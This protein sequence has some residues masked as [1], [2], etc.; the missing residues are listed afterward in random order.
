MKTYIFHALIVL[1]I[2]LLHHQIGASAQNFDIGLNYGMLGDNLPKPTEVVKLYQ[3][4]GIGKMRIFA[5]DP[6]TLEA[7]R[8]SNIELSMGIANE[9]LPT[10]A[11]SEAN[12]ER[13]Y[14]G[15]M[16]PYINDVIFSYITVGNEIVPGE[17]AQYIVPVMRNLQTI[18]DENNL[19]GIRVSTVVATS[20]LGT[21]YPPSQGNFTTDARATMID[22]L[23]FLNDTSSPLLINVY[24]YFAVAA[25]PINVRLDYALFTATDVVV[26]DGNL[27]YNNMFDAI[28]DSFFWA[29]EKENFSD[30]QLVVSESGWPSYGNGN[31]TTKPLAYTY[32]YNFVRRVQKFG[33][34]KR[35]NAYVEGFIFALFLEDLKPAGVE[36]NF[37]LVDPITME[38]LY[39]L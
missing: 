38:G 12:A 1:A 15:F 21:S 39:P 6:A 8:N 33:T 23:K 7:L 4:Y 14:N 24:P 20:V 10:L 5:P 11:A 36:R 18:L 16:A 34:P 30:V 22:I 31:L 27:N 13:W 32:N 28:V 35:P 9:L 17:F 37:G 29:M 2:T 19:A 3:K 26:Q 25:D